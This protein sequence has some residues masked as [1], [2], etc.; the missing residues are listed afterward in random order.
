M[1]RRRR[2][3]RHRLPAGFRLLVVLIV[4]VACFLAGELDGVAAP[5]VSSSSPEPVGIPGNWS[6]IFDDEFNGTEVNTA[7]W[8]ENWFSTPGEP[9]KPDNSEKDSCTSPAEVSEGGGDLDLGAVAES[10]DGYPYAAGLVDSDGKFQFTYGAFEARIYLPGDGTTVYNWPAFWTDGQQWPE[11]GEIDVMEALQGFTTCHFH[12]IGGG[13][14]GGCPNVGSGWHTFAADWEPG[15]I[16]YYYDGEEVGQITSGVTSDPMY[17][18][19]ENSVA[20]ASADTSV[21]ATLKVDY[22]RVWQT[23]GTAASTTTTTTATAAAPQPP[24]PA[25][26][27]AACAAGWWD[28]TRCG[29][30]RARGL[31]ARQTH[32][33]GGGLTGVGL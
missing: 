27:A 25:S 5:A 3:G 30:V 26:V 8:N 23:A 18:V 9:G 21:P 20:A 6:L 19:L 17:L 22:V 16:T 28:W 11:D 15:E 1:S 7:L 33:G 12:Y 29:A 24:P 4:A 10:C 2:H 13:P 31:R 32:H 14:S